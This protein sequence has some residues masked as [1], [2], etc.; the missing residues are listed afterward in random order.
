[1]PRKRCPDCLL[2]SVEIQ[3]FRGEEVDLCLCCGGIWFERGTLNRIIAAKD[4]QRYTGSYIFELGREIGQSR[5]LC[6]GCKDH[7]DTYHLLKDYHH[8]VDICRKCGG[9][10]VEKKAVSRVVDS[11]AIRD[12][13]ETLNKEVTSKTWMLQFLF[14]V[15]VEYNIKPSSRC[16][17]TWGLIILNTVIF[18]LYIFNF[19]ATYYVI[20]NFGLNPAHILV[21]QKLWTFITAMFLHGGFLHLG[22]N[23]Y[24]LWVV[25]QSLEDALGR[26]WYLGLYLFCGVAAGFVSVLLSS[27]DIPSIGASGAIAGLFGMYA[28][29]FPKASLTFMFYVY[30]KKLAVYWY[31]GIWVVLNF[32]GMALGDGGI[33]YWAHIGG[34]AFGLVI[35]AILRQSVW[36]ANPMLAYLAGPEAR[37]KR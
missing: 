12:A 2:D 15:P 8:E 20:D 6:P 22:S 16:W 19:D 5:R 28:L 24:M 14:G 36:E 37:V 33:D 26:A 4:P 27:S 29:W 11:S 25:G 34:I 10:W 31:F 21:G 18:L 17:I 30:Q 13:L 7:L 1:M 32:L 23:M 3:S 9:L 35:G